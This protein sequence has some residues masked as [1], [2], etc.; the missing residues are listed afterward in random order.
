MQTCKTVH[1]VERLS[2]RFP[3]S[4]TPPF[5]RLWPSAD[6]L[7]NICSYWSANTDN[8]NLYVNTN[9]KGNF[10]VKWIV[11]EPYEQNAVTLPY[12]SNPYFQESYLVWKE[13]PKMT[14]LNCM[15]V[16]ETAHA[17][18]TVDVSSASVQHYNLTTRPVSNSAAM[19]DLWLVHGNE[20]LASAAS[21][22]PDGAYVEVL[23]NVTVS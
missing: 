11:G 19:S 6:H 5:F 1:R 4:P 2:G 21:K 17:L 13:I 14:A 12:A 18:V 16:F 15:P 8:D 9:T 22:R 23:M 10:T 20:S 3:L 7:A